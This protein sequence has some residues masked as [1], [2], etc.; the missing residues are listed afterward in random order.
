MSQ[1]APIARSDLGVNSPTASAKRAGGAVLLVYLWW[2]LAYTDV[3][4]FAASYIGGGAIL[5]RIPIMLLIPMIVILLQRGVAGAL[6]WP[7]V[8]WTA[9]HFVTIFVAANRG[10]AFSGFKT[11]VFYLIAFT[12]ALEYQCRIR[13]IN[14]E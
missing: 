12:T 5:N 13:G 4:N 9:L 2:F 7:L 6:Y 11:M 10:M 1:A 14:K 3:D 8:F